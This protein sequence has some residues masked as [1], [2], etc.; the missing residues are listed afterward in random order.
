MENKNMTI[1]HNQYCDFSVKKMQL[2]VPF[3]FSYNMLDPHIRS[4]VQ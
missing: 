4:G 1:L 2:K 3:S